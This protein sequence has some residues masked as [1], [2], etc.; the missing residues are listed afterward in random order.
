MKK[1]V[2]LGI[3]SIFLLSSIV[4]SAQNGN[5]SPMVSKGVQHVANKKAFADENV[6]K[7][8]IQANSLE[9]PAIVIS[10]GIAQSSDQASVGNIESKGYPAWT[11]SKGVAR[12]NIE[13]NQL[14]QESQEYRPQDILQNS[15]EISKK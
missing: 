5:A 15:R 4:G 12:Q 13:H 6:K 11:V 9:F 7:S 8:H 3:M 10:K 1:L 2:G 14:K